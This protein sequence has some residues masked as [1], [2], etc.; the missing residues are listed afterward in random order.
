[1]ATVSIRYMVSVGPEKNWPDNRSDHMSI[2][3]LYGN[4]ETAKGSQAVVECCEG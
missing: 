1:M 3:A 4:M 2:T